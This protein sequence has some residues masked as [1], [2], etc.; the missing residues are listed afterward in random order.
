MSH[1]DLVALL[2]DELQ[3]VETE[4]CAYD[5]G[6]FLRIGERK[7]HIGELRYP[8]S[9]PAQSEFAAVTSTT[10]LRIKACQYGKA[11]LPT[12]DAAGELAQTVL[13][14]FHFLAVNCRTLREDFH[15]YLRGNHGQTVLRQ[16]RN[17]AADFCRSHRYVGGQL[18]LYSLREEV[19]ASRLHKYFA[20]LGYRLVIG[21][22]QSLLRTIATNILLQAVVGHHFCLLVGHRD[23]IQFGLVQEKLLNGQLFR[24][25]G[26][27]IFERLAAGLSVDAETFHI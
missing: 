6:Y 16:L 23:R 8:L 26:I 20:N 1:I 17:C 22:F 11:G 21:R 4:F 9:A 14:A 18:L 19:F 25:F 12:I 5:L 15:F 10:V 2:F 3:N 24:D 13:N 27:G 7:C